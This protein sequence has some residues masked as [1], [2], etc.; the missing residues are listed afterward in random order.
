MFATVGN[1]GALSGASQTGSPAEQKLAT[2][3]ATWSAPS[4]PRG[5]RW[6][7]PVP[8][9]GEPGGPGVAG[10]ATEQRYCRHPVRRD[11]DRAPALADIPDE[12]RRDVRTSAV[13]GDGEPGFRAAPPN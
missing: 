6:S 2:R 10:R 8:S 12:Q 4:Y 7:S 3:P 1:N 13:S 9:S 5:R 11:R